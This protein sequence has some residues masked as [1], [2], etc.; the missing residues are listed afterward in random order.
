MDA[1][2]ARRVGAKTMRIDVE[3]IRKIDK[4]RREINELNLHD[5]EWYEN[6]VRLNY[7]KEQLD[8]WR[9][10]GL[11]NVSFVEYYHDHPNSCV[12]K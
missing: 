7:T 10:I 3:E 5:I 8:E 4:R 6:G 2:C 12:N 9:F 11:S 1:N